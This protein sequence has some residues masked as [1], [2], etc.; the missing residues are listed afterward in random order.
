MQQRSAKPE[1]L[2]LGECQNNDAVGALHNPSGLLWHTSTVLR[3]DHSP[4]TRSRPGASSAVDSPWVARGRGEKKSIF[5]RWCGR[6]RK[7]LSPTGMQSDCPG[8]AARDTTTVWVCFV[9][10]SALRFPVWLTLS[11]VLGSVKPRTEERQGKCESTT[12][13]IPSSWSSNQEENLSIIWHR[14]FAHCHHPDAQ[15]PL[16]RARVHMVCGAKLECSQ[17]DGLVH[18]QA[19]I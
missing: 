7:S 18:T 17:A 3:P 2:G 12:L 8:M 9:F 11:A 6:K 1:K 13:E 15:T 10:T 16:P 19:E 14:L 4:N 5:L